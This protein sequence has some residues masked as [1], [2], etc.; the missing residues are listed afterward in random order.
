MKSIDTK[1]APRLVQEQR[2]ILTQELQLFLKLIQMTTLELREYIEEQLIENPLLEEAE[3]K[4]TES[5]DSNEVDFEFKLIENNLLS[6]KEENFKSFK[7]FTDEGE[8]EIPWEN[9]VSAPQSLLDYLQ[10]QIDISDF[11]DEE[12]KIASIIIGNTDEDGYLELDLKEIALLLVKNQGDSNLNPVINNVS[13]EE[14]MEFYENLIEGDRSYID[15]VESVLN[16]IQSSFDPPGVCA[17][18]LQEC[19]KIQAEELGYD[20][21]NP[22]LK[23]IIKVYLEE[24]ASKDYKKIADAL[25]ISIE[26]AEHAAS[27]I[28]SLEPKP[29]RPFY[30]KDT[31]KYI[32]PDFYVYKVGN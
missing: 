31:A 5:I 6:N 25:E 8:E 29:G 15:K 23:N 3:E 18:N 13:E 20:N 4:N 16:K 28:S 10:W 24:I 2:L 17:R 21:G 26:E 22:A 19:L 27:V 12:K 32:V 14:Q 1:T 11:S 7:E 30:S 9:K